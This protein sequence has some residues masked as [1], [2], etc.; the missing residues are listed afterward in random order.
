MET[1]Q[2]QLK[3]LNFF[4]IFFRKMNIICVNDFNFEKLK[5]KIG[6]IVSFGDPIYGDIKYEN[7]AKGFID[8]IYIETTACKIYI[9]N[10]HET[11]SELIPNKLP[12]ERIL[13]QSGFV[14]KPKPVNHSQIHCIDY[15][16]LYLNSS[17]EI[18]HHIELQRYCDGFHD[19]LKSLN[20][21]AN[22]KLSLDFDDDE[23]T[24]FAKD[25]YENY[26][27]MADLD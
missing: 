26:K 12:T 5:V 19:S 20:S 4:T 11:Y 10:V 13:Y 3:K 25:W 22:P 1:C 18:K 24:I 16:S 21:F 15:A 7:N 9:Q 27:N 6:D 2:M 23:M 14:S 8:R 17:E